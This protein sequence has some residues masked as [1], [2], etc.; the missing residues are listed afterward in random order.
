MDVLLIW[1]SQLIQNLSVQVF[2]GTEILKDKCIVY[3]LG[4]Y[5]FVYNALWRRDKH[6]K[7]CDKNFLP[8]GKRKNEECTQ[9][10]H[11]KCVTA[12]Q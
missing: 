3:S 10:L 2:C 6:F 1:I 4:V 8:I 7:C 5:W 12:N 11:L 9:R